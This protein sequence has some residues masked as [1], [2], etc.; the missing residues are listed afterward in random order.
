MIGAS[1]EELL[2]YLAE[3]LERMERFAVTAIA[4]DGDEE[5]GW[6]QDEAGRLVM[7][8]YGHLLAEPHAEPAELVLQERWHPEGHGAWRL[9]EYGYELRHRSLDYRRA[10]HHHDEEHFVRA[11]GVATHEHCESTMG[12]AACDHYAGEPVRGAIEGF[13]RLYA[14]WLTGEPPDCSTLRCLG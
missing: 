4:G 9:G 13:E 14:I 12:R 3:L 8:V 2:D 5:I 11:F 10:F 1:T 7:D 6:P